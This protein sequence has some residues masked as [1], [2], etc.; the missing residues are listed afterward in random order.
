MKRSPPA[1]EGERGPVTIDGAVSGSGHQ[2]LGGELV[3]A[4]VEESSVLIHRTPADLLEHLEDEGLV[5]DLRQARESDQQRAHPVA[6]VGV[7]Q[8]EANNEAPAILPRINIPA[9]PGTDVAELCVGFG[10]SEELLHRDELVLLPILLVRLFADSTLVETTPALG[11]IVGIDGD[12]HA[13]HATSS[14]TSL[15][16][17]G[18]E[19][20]TKSLGLGLL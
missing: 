10:E 7:M 8:M 15:I 16:A 11:T 14:P 9:L 17:Q 18:S 12:E 3:V 20:F 19:N 5:G 2:K 4:V 1:E 13:E 6:E